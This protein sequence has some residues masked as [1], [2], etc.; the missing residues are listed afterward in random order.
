MHSVCVVVG[1]HVT[2]NHI[3]ILRF[4]QQCLY[5]NL[6]HRQQWKLRVYATV[7]ER[8]IPTNLQSFHTLHMKAALKEKNV[9]FVHGLL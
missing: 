9:P 4:A 5:G 2:D 7:F 1:L 8:C 6:C 3:K